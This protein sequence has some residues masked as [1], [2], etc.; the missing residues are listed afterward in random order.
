[1]TPRLELRPFR[2]SDIGAITELLADPGATRFIGD[3]KSPA[4]AAESVRLMA[5]AFADRGWGTLAVVPR[6]QIDCVGY[7]GVRPL[8]HTPEVE[9]AFA[10]RQSCWNLGFA[11]EAAAAS[12]D[13]AFK[14]LGIQSIVA[15]V[16]PENTR[17]L[18]VLAKLGLKH[19][20]RVFGHWPMR[21]ALLFRIKR[22][23][24]R[25]AATAASML[26]L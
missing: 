26:P 3:V 16:Y 1:V 10:L 14:T 6:G 22:T 2:E 8:A 13:A 23:E 25:G 7:C 17:S 19:E 20:S 15:T 12:I 24:W 11:T 5:D 21:I 18:R 9:I 4:A